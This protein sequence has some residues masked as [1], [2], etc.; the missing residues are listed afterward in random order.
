VLARPWSTVPPPDA[1]R[2]VGMPFPLPSPLFKPSFV[3]V[4]ESEVR[5]QPGIERYRVQLRGPEAA[6]DLVPIFDL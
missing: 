2:E 6:G 5:E 1:I 4:A 3:Y